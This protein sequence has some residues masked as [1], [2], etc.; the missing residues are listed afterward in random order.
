MN[1]TKEKI[2]K[3]LASTTRQGT[4]VLI[5]YLEDSDFFEAP[6]ST[7]FRG[8]YK[9]G[10]AK[11]SL[12]V[13]ELL[14][15]FVVAEELDL[16]KANNSGQKP[17]PIEPNNIIIAALLHDVCKIGAY[18]GTEK[19]YKW[20][21]AQPKGHALLS[22]ER[23]KKHIELTEL[24]EMMIRYHMGVYGLRE[25]YEEDSWEYQTNAEYSLRGDHSKDEEMTKEESQKARYGQSLR[26][27]WY[28]N[29]IV[30]VMYFCDEL[31]VL[32][33]KAEE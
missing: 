22:I 5:G 24:E 25:F 20:N 23:I 29:P 7:R 12:G 18:I 11:H 26:N 16:S 13:Y 30:K 33:E 19:P 10:L 14:R 28:H 2:I 17:L 6:A 32:E 1:E 3:L 4:N 31:Q 27:A 9:G 21:K 8:C 15:D